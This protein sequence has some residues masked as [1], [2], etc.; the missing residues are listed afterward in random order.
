MDE[1][2]R[3]F[4]LRRSRRVAATVAKCRTYG[5]KNAECSFKQPIAPVRGASVVKANLLIGFDIDPAAFRKTATWKSDRVRSIAV[6]NRELQ[7][8]VQRCGI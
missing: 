2:T 1:G 8:A 4:R 7:I 6:D 3:A 5:A